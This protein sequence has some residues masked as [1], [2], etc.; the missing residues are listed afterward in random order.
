MKRKIL[1][2]SVLMMMAT[3]FITDSCKKDEPVPLNLGTLMAGTIDLNAAIAPT[4]VPVN[5]TITA[6]FTTEIDVATATSSN[7]TLTEDYDAVSIPLTISA[8]GKVVTITPVS[9]LANG[10]LYKLA[11]TTGLKA[12]NGQKLTAIDRSFT[13]E[14]SFLP[15]P[16][17]YWTFSGNANDQTGTYNAL[18]GGVTDITYVT[19]RNTTSGQAAS[20]NGTTSL[21]QI[22]NGNVLENSSDFSLSFWIKVDTTAKRNQFV[23]GLAGW[24]G[25]QFE[26]NS[27][28]YGAQKGQCKL[29][30][31]YSISDG[32]TAS[33][34]LWFDG[35][36]STKDNGGWQ[37]WTF[38]KDLN[39]GAGTGVNGLLAQQWAH[40]VC[41]YNHSTKIGTIYING[42]KMKAQDFNLYPVPLLNATGLKFAGNAANNSLVF[43]FIQDKVS[44]TILDGW[45]DY[46]VPGNNHFKGLLDDVAIFH[47]A[48]PPAVITLMYNSGKP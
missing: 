42:E 3:V 28:V 10:A 13:T 36:G 46:S 8:S 27:N 38:C 41:T 39:S 35:S 43:G 32:T 47:I 24:F 12:S 7:I 14:G 22:P 33:Q 11:I 40:V 25:F 6:T 5:P 20:F 9:N 45:A 30:A 31:Q 4:N 19:G 29:A 37:G 26:I 16:V 2:P 21:I 48:L 1:I 34:D 15:I 17:A 44:P 18:A 23:M